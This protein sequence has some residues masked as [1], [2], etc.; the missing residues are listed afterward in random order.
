MTVTK[1][2]WVS[3]TRLL[4]GVLLLVLFPISSIGCSSDGGSNTPPPAAA[5]LKSIAVNPPSATVGV[6][7][8]QQ[9]AATGTYTDG[10]TAPLTKDIT[11]SSSDP[12]IATVS[13]TGLATAVAAG[14]ATITAKVGTI[15]GTASLTVK[16]KTLTSL[17]VTPPTATIAYGTTQQF[18]ATANYDDGTNEDVSKTAT[19]ASA[20]TA[21]ATISATGLATAKAAGTTVITAAYNG[22]TGMA[23]LTV[24]PAAM[25][26]ITVTPATAS[27]AAGA[28]QAFT[29]TANFADNHTQDVTNQATWASSATAIATVNASGVATGVAAGNADISATLNGLTGTAKL[30]VTAATLTG[31]VVTPAVA[32]GNAG[33]APVQFTAT[34]TYSDNTTADVSDQATWTSSNDTLATVDATGLATPHAPGTATITA[35]FGGLTADA[36]FVIGNAVVVSIQVTPATQSIAKGT[37]LQYTATATYSDQT[38]QNITSSAQWQSSDTAVATIDATGLATG[39]AAGTASITATFNGITGNADLTVTAA[40]VTA[41]QVDPPVKTIPKG[42]TQAFT[43]T[44]IFS[45]GTNQPVTTGVSWQSS[46]TAVATISAAGVASG[47][48]AGTTKITAE[49]GGVTS[50]AATL[51]VTN[52]V[53]TSLAIT[54]ATASIAKGTTRQFTATVT[55]SDGSQQNVTSAADWTSSNPTTATIDSAGL[56]TGVAAGTTNITA[57]YQGVTAPPAVLTVTAAT[58]VSIHVSASKLSIPKGTTTTL[59]AMGSYTDGTSQDISSTVVWGQTPAGV[60]SFTS[61]IATGVTVGSTA[62]TATLSGITSNAVNIEVT[63]A[64]LTAINITPVGP[65]SLA[66]GT[67][68]QFVAVGTYSDATTQTITTDA[69]TT[70]ESSQPTKLSISNTAG[71]RGL[72]TALV[73]GNA[74][75]TAKQGSIVSNQ[76]QVT[77]TTAAT[78]SYIVLTP[79]SWSGSVG[80]TNTFNAVAWFADGTSSPLNDGTWTVEDQAGT[81][82]TN[83]SL[84][85]T[86]NANERL[87]TAVTS[88]VALPGG[89]AYVRVRKGSVEAKSPVTIADS[90]ITAIAVTCPVRNCLPSSTTVAGTYTTQPFVTKCTAI[91]TYSDQTTADVTDTATWSSGTPASAQSLGQGK[92]RILAAGTA[93][94]RAQVGTVQSPATNVPNATLTVADQTFT[95]LAVSPTSATMN[96]GQTASFTA[97]GTFTGTGTCAGSRTFNL[98]DVSSWGTQNSSVAVFSDPGV[99]TGQAAGSTT[100]WAGY[101][102]FSASVSLTVSSACIDGVTIS[103]VGVNNVV[104]TNVVVPMTVTAHYSNGTNATLTPGSVGNWSS[105]AVSPTTWKLSV[106]TT[107]PGDLTYSLSTGTC[108]GATLT[109]T[110]TVTVDATATPTGVTVTPASVTIAKGGYADFVATAS[111]SGGYGAYNVSPYATWS[112]SPT[113]AGLSH[114]AAP[115]TAATAPAERFSHT[116]NVAGSTKVLAAYKSQSS[117]L[118]DL[119]IT[120]AVP[121]TVTVL[122]TT[123]TVPAQGV[124]GGLK[125]TYSAKVHYSDGTDAVDPPCLAWT[126]DDTTYLAFAGNVADTYT[127]TTAK[128]VTVK[129]TCTEGTTVVSGTSTT[130]VNTATLSDI[131]FTPASPMTLPRNTTAPL[132][133]T[134]VYS[135]GTSFNIGALTNISTQSGGASASASNVSGA[136]IVTST[137]TSGTAIIR[138]SRGTV[139]R[140]YTVIVSTT[141]C[142]DSVSF[143][144]PTADPVVL[145]KGQTQDYVATAHNTAGGTTN[146]TPTGTWSGDN[147]Y[148]DNLGLF[149]TAPNQ[150][151][152]YRAL[153]VGNSKVTFTL[154]GANVCEGGNTADNTIVIERATNVQAATVAS[155]EIRPQPVAGQ[156][157]RR[158]PAG[159]HF[160]LQL[161]PIYTDGTEGAD[162]AGAAGVTW[163]INNTGAA[164]PTVSATGLLYSG[165]SFGVD[166]VTAAYDHDGNSATPPITAT[167][168]IDVQNCGAPALTVTT[169]G[170]GKLPVGQDRDYTASAVYAT[171]ATCTGDSTERTYAVTNFASWNSSDSGKATIQTVGGVNPGRAHGVSAGNTNISATYNGATANAPNNPL[172]VVAVTLKSL[173]TSAAASTFAGPGGATTITVSA[174][175]TDGT[176]DYTGIAPPSGLSWV[177]VDPTVITIASTSD[178]TKY[179]LTGLKTG[180]SQYR[181]QSGTILSPIASITITAACINDVRLK[182]APFVWPTGAPFGLTAECEMSNALG[183]WKPCTAAAFS[184]TGTVIEDVYSTFATK[185]EG[186]I[187]T[188]ATAGDVGT[189]TATIT[190]A[191]GACVSNK[192]ATANVTVGSATLQSIAVTGPATMAK[193]TKAVFAAAATYGG[194]TGAGSYTITPIATYA[195]SNTAVATPDNDG[196]GNVTTTT[197]GGTSYISASY[198][199]VTSPLVLVTV[200]DKVPTLLTITADPN[201]VGGPATSASIPH[202][203]TLQL[204]AKVDYSDGS[205]DNDPTGLVWTKDAAD[206]S[207]FGLSPTGLATTTATTPNGEHV[208]HAAFTYNSTTVTSPFTVNVMSG[209][210]T[211]ITIIAPDGSAAVTSVPK[212]LTQD[213]AAR[214]TINNAGAPNYWGTRNVAW[215]S[216]ASA[217]ATIAQSGAAPARLTAVNTGT[218]HITAVIGTIVG[219][220]TVTVTNATPQYVWCGPAT[221]P[222]LAGDKAQL[223]AYLHSSD[224]TN[225]E[226]TSATSTTW[227]SSAPTVADFLPADLAGVVTGLTVGT[228]KAVPAYTIGATTY[229]ADAAHQCTV[230][231][232]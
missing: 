22:Q 75:V 157:R 69:Q 183:T 91:A 170:T 156:T 154:T 100:G 108:A 42:Q 169:A 195:S 122:G 98:T 128:T 37:T 182:D 14:T 63:A 56:A 197:L 199:G 20:D 150:V 189:V 223:R 67:T 65:L 57:S 23:S 66:E 136:V 87:A 80:G 24:S 55:M 212:G 164:T 28:T 9:F 132:T 188:N 221:V 110:K 39:V 185:G 217:V 229:T 125:L 181:A 230:N 148:L 46:D 127:N 176:T 209:A 49:Y 198:L 103:N 59:T 77:V 144:L 99:V 213:Y 186:R 119:I 151:N 95:S 85:A 147:T 60:L 93:V 231:V 1:V 202:S 34:A 79:A 36:S 33:G 201:L 41:V 82:V 218:A 222:L 72:A 15:T 200:N 92:F 11:W 124:P 131:N 117:S 159:Q 165:T 224:G 109:A 30:T 6:G 89:K 204:H 18:T 155:I 51:T 32:Q 50:A 26:G 35:N 162:I 61:N 152:R 168:G 4:I 171:S 38:T 44:A 167:L 71:S 31:L 97:T 184:R 13:D 8:K 193:G 190:V 208:V 161:I 86:A 45:D 211:G 12:A 21:I 138:F 105:S 153:A 145:S 29:A 214:V 52:A 118:A 141:S 104:P 205:S 163:A 216:D 115:A 142:I 123:P 191:N 73:P 140:D 2:G 126:S 40:V 219:S 179:T 116:G 158:F 111:Y 178:P 16:A 25:T 226:V 220:L 102:N 106:G 134:G 130:L 137:S 196:T 68:K 96:A 139:Y 175:Y 78:L 74:V 48:A 120:G 58:L 228:A 172:V 232:Q 143:T 90:T 194:G 107:N 5:S 146:V 76:V 53:P 84:I 112:N 121:T 64:V 114:A 203:W 113:I 192:T 101:G 3:L 81:I 149:G 173:A 160:Q 10:T 54:P 70:W 43:A 215:Y 207:N 135:N 62:V 94:I 166:D 180:S 187:A 210:V 174:V 225:T 47:L 133:V 7:A 206:T 227:T 83:L 88:T 177:I 129:A 17:Q 19:W 27:I